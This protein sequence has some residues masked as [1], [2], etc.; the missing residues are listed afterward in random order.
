[1]AFIA[2]MTPYT[3]AGHEPLADVLAIGWLDSSMPYSRGETS[4]EFRSA[5]AALCDSPMRRFRGWHSCQFCAGRANGGNGEF[6]VRKEG[7]WYVAP[8]LIRHYISEHGYKP[9]QA[10]ID[11]VTHPDE[12][13]RD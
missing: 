11:A 5:L 6:R 9:P 12:V 1:M 13:G 4:D 7:T 8:I 10:F 2:D 3:Y